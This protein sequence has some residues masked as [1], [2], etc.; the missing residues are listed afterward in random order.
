MKVYISLIGDVL[1]AGHVRL[2]KE[3]SKYGE[4]II[5]LLTKEACAELN[6]IPFID[7][8]KRKEV[9]ESLSSVSKVI[10]QDSASYLKNLNSLKPDYVLHGNDWVNTF[11]KKYRDEVLN[12]FKNNKGKLIEIP[13]SNDVNALK[14]KESSLAANVSSYSRQQMLKYLDKNKKTIRF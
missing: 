4:V 3:G 10:K 2:I 14:I 12:Y 1:H 9:I 6:D 11:Q 8:K 13:Y 7:Y 5:G